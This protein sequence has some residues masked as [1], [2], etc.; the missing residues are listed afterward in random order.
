MVTSGMIGG[1]GYYRDLPWEFMPEAL[2]R[3]EPESP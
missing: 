3:P 2:Q 1:P